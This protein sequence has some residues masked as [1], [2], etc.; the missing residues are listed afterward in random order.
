MNI[1]KLDKR[2]SIKTIGTTVDQWNTEVTDSTSVT[3]VWA[4]VIYKGGTEK[5]SADQRVSVDRVEFLI[6]YK[7]GINERD[8]VIEYN[9]QDHD[10]HSI[11]IIGRNEGMRLITT[12]RDN[13]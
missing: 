9:S 12:C 3:N 2:I 5:Q 7:Q 6:R 8:N 13:G 1:G 11:E 4:Q 10:I